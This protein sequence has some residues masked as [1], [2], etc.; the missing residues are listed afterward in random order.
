MYIL[1]GLFPSLMFGTMN[2][3]VGKIGGNPRQQNFGLALGAGT[4]SL[5][6]VPFIDNQWSVQAFLLGFFGAIFWSFGQIFMLQA[7]KYQGVSRS[8]PVIVGVQLVQNALIGVLLLGEWQATLAFTLGISALAMIITGIYATSY[9]EGASPKSPEYNLR[10]GMFFAIISGVFYAIY[11]PM[12]QYFKLNPN[13]ALGPMGIGILFSGVVFTL[14]LSKAYPQPLFTKKLGY[15]V[16]PG[17]MWALGNLTLLISS[18]KLGVATGFTLSQLGVVISTLG[19]I[20]L[21]GEKRTKKE[22]VFVLV[23]VTL[24]V[25]GGILLGVAKSYDI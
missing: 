4:L 14:Y 9:H 13:D 23:G 15:L 25:G 21:L 17:C 10:K 12:F 11:P 2:L 22:M 19:G 6:L 1:I 20:F 3:L 5:L 16:G 8:M 24:V 18:S 7:F